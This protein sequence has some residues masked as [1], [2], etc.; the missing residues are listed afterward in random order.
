MPGCF[1]YFGSSQQEIPQTP[2]TFIDAKT[3]AAIPHVLIIPR[4]TSSNGFSS[5]GG[6]GP[7][8][9]GRSMFIA[10]PFT[11]RTGTPF[12]VS[13]PKAI[14]II[15]GLGWAWVGYGKRT[16]GVLVFAPGFKSLW[17]WDLWGKF[18]HFRHMLTPLEADDATR[19][20]DA[21]RSLLDQE[22]L[23]GSENERRW[24]VGNSLTILNQL[25]DEDKAVIRTFLSDL[26]LS[27]TA[28]S[29]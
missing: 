20:R 29:P 26:P 12:A 21:I 25:T 24:A 4:Y 5:G 7:E 14:G 10:H 9:L 13:Q 1:P 16:D 23:E 28:S 8:R 15:F 18:D 6:H 27:K 3:G 19:E 11:Y 17:V 22:R 2:H